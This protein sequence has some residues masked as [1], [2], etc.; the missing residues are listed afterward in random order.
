[1]HHPD[2]IV[3]VGGEAGDLAQDPVVRQRLGPERINLEHR[4][5]ARV[6]RIGPGGPYGDGD[7]EGQ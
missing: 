2:A 6:L 4:H 7:R 5:G 3:A 1:M